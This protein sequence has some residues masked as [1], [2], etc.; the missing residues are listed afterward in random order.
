MGGSTGVHLLRGIAY[1]TAQVS[2]YLWV[3]RLKIAFILKP[4]LLPSSTSIGCLCW[5]NNKPPF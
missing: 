1:T 4:S 5:T 2:A 3:H